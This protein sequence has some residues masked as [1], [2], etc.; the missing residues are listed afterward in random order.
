MDSGIGS[1]GCWRTWSAPGKWC[2]NAYLFALTVV[3]VSL[4]ALVVSSA[5]TL[6]T[7]RAVLTRSVGLE[8][9][10]APPDVSDVAPHVR[11]ASA[12][13]RVGGEL[14]I[15]QDDVNAVAIYAGG[16]VRAVLLPPG[17]N[18][19]RSFSEERGNK[20]HKL[21]LEASVVLPDGRL[22]AFGSGS[23]AA[24][25]RVVTMAPDGAVTVHH[26]APLYAAMR[27]NHGFSGSELN[28]EGAVVLGDVLRFLQRGNGAVVD[29][30]K[31]VNATADV[32][33]QPF[34]A[35]LDAGAVLPALERVTRYDLGQVDG[36][37]WT[38]TD[39]TVVGGEVVFVG[40]A[41]ASP[42]TYRD[43]EVVGSCLG[44]LTEDGPQVFPVLDR[45]GALAKIKLEGIDYR[46]GTEWSFDVVA[47]MDDPKVPA[48]LGVVELV[49]K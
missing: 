12:V 43:G 8:Y 25:E 24:R 4:A 23:T 19:A 26:G 6:N 14:W 38:F 1:V 7:H 48:V 29:G 39:A 15:V 13:R 49:R 31:P 27:Q 46:P 42:D 22:L 41:E 21:D 20:R 18:G 11:A 33:L 35:W 2:C 37:P 47:D 40:A 36:V 10:S 28:I 45:G 3:A 16:E 9:S 30:R 5:V 44:I 17:V 32:P 34:L